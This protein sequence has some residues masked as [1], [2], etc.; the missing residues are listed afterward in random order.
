M[1]TTNQTSR[2]TKSILCEEEYLSTLARIDKLMDSE[3]GNPGG[4][5][6]EHLVNLVESYEAQHFPMG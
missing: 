3:A 5:E 1:V 4:E 6:L 2:N